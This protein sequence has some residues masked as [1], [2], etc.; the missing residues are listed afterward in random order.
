MSVLLV[1]RSIHPLVTSGYCEKTAD[2]IELPSG[3]VG[4]VGPRS[5]VLEM[6]VQVRATR[7]NGQFLGRW[8]VTYRKNVTE[9]GTMVWM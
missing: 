8:N 9:C 1:G 2:S 6:G 7:Y 3:V 5:H 4:R